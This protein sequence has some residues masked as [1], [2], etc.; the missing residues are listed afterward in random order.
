M[1]KKETPGERLDRRMREILNG[2]TEDTVLNAVIGL[3]GLGLS[4]R[5]A[6]RTV[7]KVLADKER[8]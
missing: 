4:L 1:R 2:V 8:Q 6:F 5:Q 3:A 7:E